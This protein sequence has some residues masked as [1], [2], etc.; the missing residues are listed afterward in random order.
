MSVSSAVRSATRTT[1]SS[2]SKV[3]RAAEEWEKKHNLSVGSVA[4]VEDYNRVTTPDLDNVKVNLL[5][6]Y[7][8]E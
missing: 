4:S 5:Y 8:T 6:T 7:I 3:A 1:K 2:S